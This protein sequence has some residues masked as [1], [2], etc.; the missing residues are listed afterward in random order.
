M[1]DRVNPEDQASLGGEKE[2]TL[3]ASPFSS[4]TRAKA[5]AM[6]ASIAELNHL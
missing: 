4:T 5:N 2:S 1:R 3:R 6:S